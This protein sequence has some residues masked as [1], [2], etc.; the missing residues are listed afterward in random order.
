MDMA[1]NSPLD[2]SHSGIEAGYMG[3]M[4]DHGSGAAGKRIRKPSQL[5]EGFES[6]GMPPINHIVPSGPPQP[7]VKDPNR[8]GRMTNQLQFLQKIVLKSLWRHHFAWPFHEPVDSIRL[9][10]PDYH[11]IIKNPMDMGSIKKRLENNYYRTASECMQD[12]NTMFTNC[13]IYNKPTDDIVLMAQSLEKAFLQKVAQ[14]PQDEIELAS[15]PPRS[16]SAKSSKKGRNNPGVLYTGGMTT[17]HQVPAVSQSAYSP[18]TPETPDSILSTPPQTILGKILTPT[19]HSEQSLPAITAMPPTQPTTKK[20]GVKRKADTTTPT[21]SAISAGRADSPSAQDTKPAKLASSRRE[22]AARPAKTRRETVEE[23]VVGD[24]GGGV[25]AAG[26]RKGGKLGEQMKHCDAILKEMLSKKHAA[27]AWP[28]YK[29]VDAEALELHDYHDIIK[30]PMDLGSIKKKLDNRQYRDAQEFAADIRL[31]FS[32]CY[33][34]NPPDHDVVSMAHKLQDVFEMRFAKM[35]DDPEEPTP[36]PTLSSVLLSAPSARQAPPPPAVSEDDSS[37]SSESESSRA[38]SEQDRKQRLAELQEQLKAVHEQLA[39]LSQP[40]A[41][42]PKKKERDK[43]E[44]KKEKHKKK[45]GTEE[46]EE[47]SPL[48]ILPSKK[49]KSTKDPVMAKKDRKKPNKKEG[50]KNSRP[51]PP[52]QAGPIPLVPSASLEAEDDIDLSPEKFKPMSYE[53]KRQLSLDINKLPGDKLGRVVHIIQTR[54]PSLKNSNPDEIEID[55]ETLKPSTLRE[56]EK[57]VSSCLKKKKKPSAEKSLEST[58]VTK[59]RTGSSSSDSSDSSDSED[60][61]SG[62]VPKQQKKISVNKDTKRPHHQPLSTGVGPVTSAP[63]TQPQLVQSKPSFVPPPPS[64]PA[65]VPSLDSSQLMA[66][67]FDPLANFMNSQLTQSNTES[68]VPM[69]AAGALV[70]SGLL[71]ANMPINQTPTD[72]HPFL[73]QLPI[74]PSPAIHIALPQQPSRPSNRAA[75]L[76]PK[77]PQPPPSSLPHLPPSSSAQLQPTLPLNLP[78]P[79]P[80]PRVP[81]PPSHGILGTLSAQPPQALL[82]D[83]EEPTSNNSETPPLSQVHSLLQSLQPRPTT[84]P[85]SLPTHSPGQVAPQLVP[86]MHTQGL[87]TNTPALTQRHIPSH[88]PQSFPHSNTLAS[89]QQKGGVLQQKQQQQQLM[90]RG[91]PVRDSISRGGASAGDGAVLESRGV[92]P[93]AEGRCNTV[94]E[95]SQR[96]LS[97]LRNRKLLDDWTTVEEL[98][99]HGNRLDNQ[100]AMLCPSSLLTVTTV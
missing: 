71:N 80:R 83:D 21:T 75:P 70:S 86:S 81:S 27:Y 10:L 40:Q 16:K 73:N 32:N 85:L 12:F 55:F 29:P 35:P 8:L 87:T 52:L 63:P 5:Y 9:G 33:K 78:Q 34:Y 91:V 76:P 6:P 44:K 77:H 92:G 31:M 1:V 97:R 49:S 19:F 15:P 100:E 62:L 36:V 59:T 61:D 99:S 42:K 48:A 68:S 46:S 96:K 23:L 39:A 95:M 30:H 57:Y 60:S 51:A 45:T 3:V 14:M 72:T 67:G 65:S 90:A 82:E 47:M 25:A 50:I 26:G 54:E 7:L 94:L 89:L 11:K 41:S 84:L 74:I 24:V 88:M 43:K 64:V 17:A 93:F 58:A 53:E 37:S 79:V 18:P 4:M 20:K 22:A 56:L 13:Y 38:D 69:T 2:S 98:L 28:F 66:S